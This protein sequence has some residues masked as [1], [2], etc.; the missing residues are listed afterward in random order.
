MIAVWAV[1]CTCAYHDERLVVLVLAGLWHQ[2]QAQDAAGT[3]AGVEHA[4]AEI[5]GKA[6]AGKS[7]AASGTLP[8]QRH[9]HPDGV[10]EPQVGDV[11]Q[12]LCCWLCCQ[13]LHRDFWG[14]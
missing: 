3:G 5:S 10:V 9:D 4:E 7:R 6:K 11:M 8:T 14:A 2:A 12:L 1:R 13:Q